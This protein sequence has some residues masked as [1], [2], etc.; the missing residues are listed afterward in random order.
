MYAI[1]FPITVRAN[2]LIFNI[3]KYIWL[4]SSFYLLFII[5]FYDD[6]ISQGKISGTFF[7]LMTVFQVVFNLIVKKYKVVGKIEFCEEQIKVND[8]LVF[9]TEDVSNIEIYY[10]GFDGESYGV[11]IAGLSAKNGAENSVKFTYKNKEYKFEFYINDKNSLSLNYILK[12]WKEKG[13]DYKLY[14]YYK[15]QNDFIKH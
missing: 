9:K 6:N 14:N 8:N 11:F 4:S 15:R 1:V 3:V 5:I 7:L 13:I 2:K 10:N 12:E